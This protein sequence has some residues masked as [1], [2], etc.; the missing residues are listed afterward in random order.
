MT[1]KQTIAKEGRR[2]NNYFEL[3]GI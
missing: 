1:T 3:A 2:H